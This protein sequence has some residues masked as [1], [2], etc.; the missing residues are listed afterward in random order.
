M[1]RWH[2]LLVVAAAGAMVNVA[3]PSA[4]QA[5]ASYGWWTVTSV[6]GE[7]GLQPAPDVPTG[8]FV[9][10]GGPE[11]PRSFAA[12]LYLLQAQATAGALSLRV[13]EGSA[14]TPQAA[15]LACPLENNSFDAA[16]GGSMADAP[17]FDCSARSVRGVA[18]DDGSSFTF[19]VALLRTGN[20]IAIA[21]VGAAPA[22]R[23]V[24]D[25]PSGESLAVRDSESASPTSPTS[26][27][28]SQSTADSAVAERNV[29]P[30]MPTADFS[31]V[32]AIPGAHD[33]VVEPQA[34][35][36]AADVPRIAQPTAMRT[37][38]PT[39]GV[40]DTSASGWLRLLAALTVV[41][42]TASWVLAGRSRPLISESL[43]D[44][45][46]DL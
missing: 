35:T 39:D 22:D 9:I 32:R 14:T 41:A 23:I 30:S 21:L 27:T 16:H 8:G 19:D 2:R 26:P 17:K 43:E 20:E 46:G 29:A 6:S 13:A 1:R 37:S 38:L 25:A 34:D 40:V 4:A 10:E 5:P 11:A 7:T 36:A 3:T 18:T 44:E 42:M 15:V 45:A 28:P 33:F 12:L 31:S 24:F